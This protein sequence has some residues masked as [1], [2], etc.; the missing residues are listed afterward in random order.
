MRD[1][2]VL[3]LS[4]REIS[5]HV[6]LLYIDSEEKPRSRYVEQLIWE[7]ERATQTI[8]VIK[9]DKK[10]YKINVRL[11]STLPVIEKTEKI[12]NILRERI[13]SPSAIDDYIAAC[14]FLL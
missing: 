6:H 8:N 4:S 5:P 7:R 10:T 9:V 13:F 1:I 11:Q 3:F 2:P 14:F 12:R